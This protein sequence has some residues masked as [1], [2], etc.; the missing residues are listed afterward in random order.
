[1]L[2]VEVSWFWLDHSYVPMGSNDCLTLWVVNW[3]VFNK[4]LLYKL[5]HTVS[6]HN[7]TDKQDSL[8]LCSIMQLDV[9]T[10]LTLFS[11]SQFITKFHYKPG[12][13]KIVNLFIQCISVRLIF[14]AVWLE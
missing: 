7:E 6:N 3:V 11:L 14:L 5:Q 4:L 12:L 2:L 9:S 13:S 10:Q 1:M 8:S